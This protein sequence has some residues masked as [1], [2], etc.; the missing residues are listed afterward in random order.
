MNNKT[1]KIP[2]IGCDGC[3][4]TIKSEIGTLAGVQHVTGDVNSKFVT[5]EWNP[6]TTWESIVAKL[7]EIDYPPQAI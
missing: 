6:P 5:V 3:V 2:N 1:V 7:T 4:N